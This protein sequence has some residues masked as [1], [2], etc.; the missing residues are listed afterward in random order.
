MDQTYVRCGKLFTGT[1][2]DILTNHTVVMEGEHVK[3]VAPSDS[4]PSNPATQ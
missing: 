3:L 1:S 4:L 2:D